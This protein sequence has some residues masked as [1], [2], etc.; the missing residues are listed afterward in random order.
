MSVDAGPRPLVDL[1]HETPTQIAVSSRVDNPHDWVEHLVDGR[2][3]TAWNSKT[4]DLV[5]GWFGFKVD[6][7]VRVRRLE[8]AV[9]Y[10]GRSKRGEDL[11]AM[12]HRITRIRVTRNGEVVLEKD[13]DAESRKLQAINVDTEGG[14]FRITVL[15]VRPGTHAAW[16]ELAVSELRVLGDVPETMARARS[17]Q[18]PEVFVGDYSHR[19]KHRVDTGSAA[20]DAT[21]S[22][23]PRKSW[24]IAIPD[25]PLDA[26]PAG[27]SAC[28]YFR[29]MRL[30]RLEGGTEPE[31]DDEL[32]KRLADMKTELSRYF[33][34]AEATGGAWVTWL[35]DIELPPTDDDGRPF[36]PSFSGMLSIGF[37]ERDTSGAVILRK[38]TFIDPTSTCTD[39]HCDRIYHDEFR[40]VGHLRLNPLGDIDGDGSPDVELSGDVNVHTCSPEEPPPTP[41]KVYFARKGEAVRWIHA[42]KDRATR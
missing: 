6:P 4:G 8:L 27:E 17:S 1:L 39:N 28:G 19:A 24:K 12:N 14:E 38:S 2:L 7:R 35:S 42:P 22:P 5:G 23:T 30:P 33:A 18:M 36:P 10:L 29:R 40:Q 34:C 41:F 3:E 13:L 16:R 31:P 25:G 11:F 26:I 32:G 37:L 15:A 20:P 9:G 21:V